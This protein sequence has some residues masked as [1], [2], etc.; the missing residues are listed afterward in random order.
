MCRRGGIG[1]SRPDNV[2]RRKG[3]DAVERG[4]GEGYNILKEFGG[5]S[6]FGANGGNKGKTRRDRKL[7]RQR[8]WRDRYPN[9][10]VVV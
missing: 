3:Q 8:G 2:L 5:R 10:W 9:I 1:R 4:K 6:R 7:G